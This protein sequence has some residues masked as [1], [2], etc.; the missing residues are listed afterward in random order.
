MK[1]KET[2]L[3]SMGKG[4]YY[5]ENGRLVMDLGAYATGLEYACDVRAI[6][7]GKPSEQFYSSALDLLG[8]IEAQ[9]AVMIGDDILGDVEGSQKMG[10]KG[11][12]VKTGKF[13]AGR[14][15][16]H[17]RVKPDA[18]VGKFGNCHKVNSQQ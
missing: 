7:I 1:N 2:K 6:V 14:D 16:Q 18:V 11:I 10:M 12:L 13:R 8:G 9:D 15:D 5:Q 4:R 3:I 17:P